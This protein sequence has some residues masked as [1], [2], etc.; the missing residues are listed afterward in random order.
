MGHLRKNACTRSLSSGGSAVK[1]QQRIVIVDDVHLPAD[2][3]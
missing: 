2:D 3:A 1:E